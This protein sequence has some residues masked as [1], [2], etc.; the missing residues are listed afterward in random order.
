MASESSDISLDISEES[1]VENDKVETVIN[2]DVEEKVRIIKTAEDLEHLDE[3]IDNVEQMEL[4]K[5]IAEFKEELKKPVAK[6]EVE[7]AQSSDSS[8]T[9]FSDVEESDHMNVGN[10]NDDR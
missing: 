7:E 3:V 5:D 9:I 4:E 1:V 6:P 10:E 8:I 2:N